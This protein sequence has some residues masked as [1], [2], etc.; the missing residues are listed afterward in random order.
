VGTLAFEDA[1]MPERWALMLMVLAGALS[2]A[3]HL[4]LY[5]AYQ[6]GEARTVAPFMYSLTIWAV[7]AGLFV[8]GEIPNSLA[9]A[10][11]ALVALAGLAIIWVDG[12]QR[13]LA[14][15]VQN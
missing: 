15:A 5:M 9:I 10:G 12:H 13:R 14:R 1:V 7:L 8:F 4:L 3:G 6:L 2:M 11:M